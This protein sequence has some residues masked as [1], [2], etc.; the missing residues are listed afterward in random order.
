M[1][2]LCMNI[3]KDAQ[4]LKMKERNKMLK[5]IMISIRRNLLKIDWFRRKVD[6]YRVEQEKQQLYEHWA[7][8]MHSG[9]T[10]RND[11]KS[12]KPSDDDTLMIVD[13]CGMAEGKSGR[14]GYID[15]LN[16]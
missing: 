1:N 14:P 15:S 5:K 3:A 10:V 6:A 16:W 9:C 2:A 13:D 4:L 12:L 11:V 8:I 7:R